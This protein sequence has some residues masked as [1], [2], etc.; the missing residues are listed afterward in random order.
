[1]TGQPWRHRERGSSAAFVAV[2]ALPLFL[3]F[4][5]VL[6]GGRALDARITAK[7]AAAEAARAAASDCDPAALRQQNGQCVVWPDVAFARAQQY[8][9]ANLP[10]AILLAAEPRLVSVGGSRTITEVTVRVRYHVS[11]AF[12]GA[13]GVHQFTVEAVQSAYTYTS[14]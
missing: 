12:L 4:G 9:Q 14:G 5:L 1:M 2:M 8:L 7:N 6:D 13:V 11:S 10:G 3:L